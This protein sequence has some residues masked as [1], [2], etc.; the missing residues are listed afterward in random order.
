[1]SQGILELNARRKKLKMPVDV[2]VKRS[3]VP[4]P[5][6]FRILQGKIDTVRYG[7]VAKVAGVL[8][9]TFGTAP[10]DPDEM[11]KNEAKRKARL[12]ARLTQG[13]M[14]L[15]SQAVSADA[16]KDFEKETVVRLLA[17]SGRKL[18]G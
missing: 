17:D 7:Y 1:M 4:R 8:G 5:T 15:E 14:G 12:L 13:T 16:L 11:R 3:R 9:L 18:W 10:L 6:V 2:L